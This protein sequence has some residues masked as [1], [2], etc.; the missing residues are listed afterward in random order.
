MEEVSTNK[1]RV[2]FLTEHYDLSTNNAKAL[3]LAEMGFSHSGIAKHLDVTRSTAKGY[4]RN[5]ENEIGPEVTQTVPKPVNYATH[6]DSTPKSE[7]EYAGD[8]IDYAP[9]FKER[10]K[11]LNRGMDI[12]DIDPELTTIRTE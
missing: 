8:F 4:L 12:E 1:E 10:Q 9:E 2:E 6:P 5:L 11:P 3:L 7:V